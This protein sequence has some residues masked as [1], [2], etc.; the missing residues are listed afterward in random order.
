MTIHNVP[1]KMAEL[2]ANIHRISKPK[3]Q[4]D[5][6][7]TVVPVKE[8]VPNYKEYIQFLLKNRHS[9]FPLSLGTEIHNNREHFIVID[10]N[11]RINAIVHFL[12]QPY[13]LFSEYYEPLMSMLSAETDIS[14]EDRQRYSAHVQGLSYH[15]ISTFRRLDEI[16]PECNLHATLFRKIEDEMVRIQKKMLFPDNTSYDT[17]IELNI[18]IFKHGTCDEYCE[19]FEE[20][21]KHANTLSKNEILSAVLFTTVVHIDDARFRH[22]LLVKIKEYYDGR[23]TKEALEQYNFVIQIDEET[24]N[25]FDFMIGFQNLCAD[26]YPGIPQFEASG[27]LSLFFKM[28][29]TIFGS[30]EKSAFTQENVQQ[31]IDDMLF[32]GELFTSALSTLFPP[33]VNEKIFN[34]CSVKYKN[35]VKTSP[36]LIIF[37]TILANRGHMS[38]DVLQKKITLAILYH[39]LS[40]RKFLKLLTEEEFSI[41]KV[42]D[43]LDYHGG[44]VYVD[45]ICQSIA[46]D[47][48]NL[49]IDIPETSF[50]KLLRACMRCNLCET[51]ERAVRVRNTRRHLNFLDKI[52]LCNF[53]NR[54]IPNKFLSNAYSL[55]HITPFSSMWS[56]ELDIDRIGNLFPTFEDINRERGNGDL[57]I[58]TTKVPEFCSAIRQILPLDQ[59]S[60]INIRKDRKTSIVSV[61]MYNEYCE[62]NEE[63]YLSNLMD[64]LYRV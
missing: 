17:A 64:E 12:L 9:V 21:N 35:V 31:F 19:I 7:W 24:M 27:I 44:G 4:R 30:I 62:R 42:D 55:E 10:G 5:Q 41:I 46:K 20:I 57:A 11:N 60:K 32:I 51:E 26:K 25:V 1:W 6:K 50:A 59:Y 61:D 45:R 13:D 16:F 47:K 54:N 18:N 58:Y 33:N 39:V 48:R 37:T 23:G 14:P 3:F 2:F 53:W 40:N 63:I 36:M 29:K 8:N 43:R 28:Y 34:K 15:T 52:L 22:D 56:G 49:I 38:K